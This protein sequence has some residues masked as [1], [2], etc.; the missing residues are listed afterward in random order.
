MWRLYVAA[1]VGQQ[2]QIWGYKKMVKIIDCQNSC[3]SIKF[4]F[5]HL[6]FG[7]HIRVE[8]EPLNTTERERNLCSSQSLRYITL[9][10]VHNQV[11]LHWCRARLNSNFAEWVLIVFRDESRFQIQRRICRMRMQR[12]VPALTIESRHTHISHVWFR[13]ALWSRVLLLQ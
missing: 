3:Y 6:T 4:L 7:P 13:H 8:P 10:L 11:W 5:I 12:G 2:R 1:R 9:N